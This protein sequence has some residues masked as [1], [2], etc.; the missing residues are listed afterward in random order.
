M[1]HWYEQRNKPTLNEE[2]A[3]LQPVK[4]YVAEEEISALKAINKI[5]L[6]V[7]KNKR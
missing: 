2:F 4:N 7:L 6:S 5:G 1:I 3:L